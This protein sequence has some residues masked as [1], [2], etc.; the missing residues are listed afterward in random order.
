MMKDREIIE[1]LIESVEDYVIA[2]IRVAHN[3]VL[4]P[5][6]RDQLTLMRRRTLLDMLEKA[7]VE[8]PD[9]FQ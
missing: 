8:A 6:F 1:Q 4:K 2:I 7:A 9:V 5:G 3:N